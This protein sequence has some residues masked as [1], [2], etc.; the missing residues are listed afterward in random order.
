MLY[1]V[2]SDVVRFAR[3]SP[4]QRNDRAVNCSYSAAPINVSIVRL[5]STDSEQ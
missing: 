4:Q 5:S 1:R 3:Q 2:D